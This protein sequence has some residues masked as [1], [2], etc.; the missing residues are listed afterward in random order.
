MVRYS[1]TLP[2]HDNAGR[3]LRAAHKRASTYLLA[4]FGAYTAHDA[5]GAWNGVGTTHSEPVVVYTVDAPDTSEACAR[6]HALATQLK[7]DARQEA[8][9]LTRQLIETWLV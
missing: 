2:T 7:A 6:L 1:L 4:H 8:V 3:D 5:E 9:Y